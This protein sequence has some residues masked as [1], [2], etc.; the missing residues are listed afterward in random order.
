MRVFLGFVRFCYVLLG[1]GRFSVGFPSPRSPQAAEEQAAAEKAA[2]EKAA[3]KQEAAYKEAANTFLHTNVFREGVG[4][5][6]K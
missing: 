1:L 6:S 5:C 3:A 2:A 4:F